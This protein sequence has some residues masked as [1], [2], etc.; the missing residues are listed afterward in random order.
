[1]HIFNEYFD[2]VLIINLERDVN[3]MRN[4]DNLC[5][6]EGL[7]YERCNAIDGSKKDKYNEY[8]TKPC[9]WLCTNGMIGCALSHYFIWKRVVEERI[10]RILVLE[11]DIYFMD[12]YKDV[13]KEA[14]KELPE[15]W[16][17]FYLGCHGLC[18]KRN[19]NINLFMGVMH[20]IKNNGD[21][22]SEK[23]HVFIPELAL[24]T[25]CYAI[26][27]DG[28][29]KLL[30]YL[31][32]ISYHIDMS[33]ALKASKLRVYACEPNLAYQ[34]GDDSSLA[35]KSFPRLLNRCVSKMRDK[36]NFTY[37]YYFTVP[38]CKGVNLWTL[39]FLALGILAKR[40]LYLKYFIMGL[41]LLELQLNNINYTTSLLIFVM[42]YY[43]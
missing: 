18:N 35:D 19:Q 28:C 25:H 38:I 4:M 5:K 40:R 22:M 12:G 21:S 3:R 6:K 29:K 37:D 33:I 41:F 2:K 27:Y 10:D 39:I 30:E 24:T 32:K 16:D 36:R 13:F 1:M 17:M 11:D 43:L 7:M 8:I 42:G 9:Q 31:N 15:D 14:I 23:K 26:T 34:R 20:L